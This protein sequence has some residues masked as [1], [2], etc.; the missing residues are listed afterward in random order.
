MQPETHICQNCKQDFRIEPEDFAFYEKI[1]VPPPTWCWQ[2]RAMRRMSFRNLT[3]LYPRTCAATGEKIY[4]TMPPE[5]PMPVYDFKYWISDAWDAS[6]YG[7]EYDFSRPF[8]EQIKELYNTVPWSVMWSVGAMNSEYSVAAWAK[9]CYLCFD[10]GFTEDSAYGVSL[11]RSKQCF[12][13]INCKYCELCYYS[14]NTSHSFKTFFSRNCVSCNEVWFSQDCVGCT[15]CF[16]C[17]GLRNKSY[18]IFNE[19]YTKDA[20]KE[21]LSNM[22]L[23][24]WTGIQNA[25]QVAEVSWLKYPVKFQHSVQAN[26]CSGDYLFN[27][28]QLRNCFFS[29]GAQ[30]CAHSQSII[31][32]PIKDCMDITS[33]GEAVELCY[34]MSDSGVNMAKAFFSFDVGVITSCQYSINCSN[35]NNVFGCVGVRKKDYCIL[36]KQYTKEEYN[37]LVPK[38]I[39]HMNDMPYIDA[40]GRVY[41]YGEFFPPEMSP[42][43]YNMTQGQE[44]F[45]MTET[46]A[47][48]WGFHWR[49]PEKKQY[50]ITKT[51]Q[52]LPDSIGDTGDEILKE[53]IQCVH[54][55]KNEH[56]WNCESN[57][58]TAFKITP[59]E[60]QFHRQVNL[61]LPR[62]CFH[63]RHFERVAWRNKPA[64]YKRNCE[65]GGKTSQ[66]TVYTNQVEHFHGFSTCP[67]EFETSYASDRSEIVYC[68]QCY[69]AEV[70]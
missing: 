38:I 25:R 53:A 46:Q 2:C 64:L 15:S 10:T 47:K 4:T 61:P 60:L 8:F 50:A 30:N 19:S 67:S 69:N 49:A 31:Y 17:T 54:A 23:D 39:T 57:C 5:A 33:T 62:L 37:A 48:D 20:Y 43:G 22:K 44:Y 24:S 34:E 59:Q 11:Q 26:G 9:N 16:G 29:D 65:C 56:P 40:R 42:Y 45:P 1:K 36:N 52:N 12:D 7:R 28:S 14:I 51:S 27:V 21:K 32:S 68:E 66:N 55:E 70:V 63:C 6:E 13:V 35:A 41:K 18:Y 58:A 3:H